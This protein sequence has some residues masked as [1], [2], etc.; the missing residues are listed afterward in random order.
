MRC[1]CEVVSNR[2]PRW[3]GLLLVNTLTLSRLL[4]AIAF[5]F[6]SRP[7]QLPAIVFGA[8]TDAVDGWLARKLNATSWQGG[9]VDGVADKLFVLSVLGS[10]WWQDLLEPWQIAWVLMRDLTVAAVAVS[11]ALQRKW[12]AFQRMPSRRAGK[13][14]TF[15]QFVLMTIALAAPEWTLVVSIVCGI[16]STVAAAD[17]L[18]LYRRHRDRPRDG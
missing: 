13:L 18:A 1:Y 15:T 12:Y 14:A 7:W 8:G 9:L 4:I 11:I 5:P 6:L 10:L 2:F 3:L 16:V 17:Y